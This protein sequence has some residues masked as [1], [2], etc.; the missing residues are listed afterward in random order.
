MLRAGD[1][2]EVRSKEEILATLDKNG[3]CEQMPF[4]PQQFACCGQRFRVAK[5]ADKTCD[6]VSGHYVGRRLENTVHLEHR[7]DGRAYGGCQARC[8]IFWKE[9]WL[10]PVD[11]A[12]AHAAAPA[13]AAAGVP[14]ST[15]TEADVIAATR[16]P[17]P[18]PARYSCQATRLL[19][20]TQPLKWWDPRQYI[21]AYRSG[22]VTLPALLRGLAYLAYFYGTFARNET[23]GRPSRWLYDRFQSFWGGFPFPRRTGTIPLA[24][25][26]PRA[27]LGLRPG[28][29]VRMKSYEA[30][31]ATLDRN[32]SNRGLSFDAEFVPYCGRIFRVSH[33][34][35]RFV[36][37]KTGL[38]RTL[39]T[40]AVILDNV[41][42]RAMFSGQR[43]FCPRSIYLW[44][45]EIWLERVTEGAPEVPSETA[46]HSRGA[47][48]AAATASSRE[49]N[50]WGCAS[51]PACQRVERHL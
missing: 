31:L 15:T 33:Q 8:L 32:S 39:K 47:L 28:E 49:V 14:V 25:M 27:D 19:E 13:I 9:A 40:P 16:V 7:C 5:R 21:L 3:R 26:T 29:L 38:M 46:S 10:K 37:E 4:M 34:I 42:C 6:T 20:Y 18:G 48:A 44:C 24:S 45:R 43:M 23:F 12:S 22:N 41:V 35:E 1:W 11:A 51:P 50:A 2:V 36:D 17:G 30:I